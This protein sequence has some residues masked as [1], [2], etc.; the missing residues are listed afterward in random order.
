MR[1]GSNQISAPVMNAACSVAKT[2]ADVKALCQTKAGI[3]LVGS[4]TT[5]PREGNPEPRWFD[6][7]DY[8]LNSMGLPNPGAEFY[9]QALPK[10]RD[11]AHRA[12]KPL[13]ISIAGHSL[14]DYLELAKLAAETE[15]DIVE[16]NLGCPNVSDGGIISFNPQLISDIIAGVHGITDKPLFVKLSPYS[17]PEELAHI[18]GRIGESEKVTAVV[19]S[20][21]F[22]NGFMMEGGKPVIKNEL[23]GVSGRAML[24]IGLGQV[25]QFRKLLPENIKVIGV[26]GVETKAD[27]ELYFQAGADMVQ[28]ATLIVRDGHA[29]L[30][31]LIST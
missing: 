3:V 25:K 4:I 31:R 17:N 10:M 12:G 27:T 15:V 5:L 24:P 8:A 1:I 19:T 6:G 28:T 9:K 30:N 13:A 20:N 7:G 2:L 11:M 26:G 22:P 14:E 29:A 16:L 21:T 23:A 18:A